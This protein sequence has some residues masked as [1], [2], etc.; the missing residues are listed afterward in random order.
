MPNGDDHDALTALQA[1]C[2]MHCEVVRTSME[3]LGAHIS[4]HSAQ[5]EARF[6]QIEAK[7]DRDYV[8]RLEFVPVQRLVYGLVALVLSGAL[9]ALG[10]LIVET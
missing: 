2:A 10:K 7:L 6:T 1:Q 3:K 8:Q 9:V 4:E 5:Q